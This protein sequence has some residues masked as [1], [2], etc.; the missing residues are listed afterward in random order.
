M[1]VAAPVRRSTETE[2][3]RITLRGVSWET[4][5]RL[6]TDFEDRRVPRF[7]YDEGVLEI[8]SPT[9]DHEKDLFALT[10]LVI[11]VADEWEIDYLPVGSTTY[12]REGIEK[13]FEADSGFYITNERFARDL[14]TIDPRVDPPPDLVIGIDVSRSSLDKLP[15]YAAFGVPEVWRLRRDRV[16]LLVLAGDA[17]QEVDQSA[18][19]PAL[20]GKVL[21]RF[22]VESRS[23]RRRDW[24][25]GVRAWARD[26][27]PGAGERRG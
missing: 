13:G 22:I 26:H 14:D 5:E 8:A 21:T 6:L 24:E 17:Y 16:G 9:P 19:L 1:A 4:Y 2:Q 25:R 27:R 15:I 11:V 20:T 7:T 10:Q 23:R 3:E 18:V 12:R